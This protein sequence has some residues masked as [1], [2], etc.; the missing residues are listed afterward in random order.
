MKPC[1]CTWSSKL[2]V[3]KVELEARIVGRCRTL[4]FGACVFAACKYV[5]RVITST[6]QQVN[7]E[8]QDS[9]VPV[10]QDGEGPSMG[11]ASLDGYRNSPP[12]GIVTE[13]SSAA[14]SARSVYYTSD[15]SG[16]DFLGSR[17]GLES[18]NDMRR[19]A[20]NEI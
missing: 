7:H 16:S 15:L 12:T 13:S 9:N 5:P 8:T 17:A 2:E 11:T 4:K 10:V 6:S 1:A 14:L 20:T 18:L 19:N 3:L